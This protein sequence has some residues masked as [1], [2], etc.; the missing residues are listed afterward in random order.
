MVKDA[1]LKFALSCLSLKLLA[2]R[3]I[4]VRHRDALR[5]IRK[6][7]SGWLSRTA[8]MDPVSVANSI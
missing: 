8:F 1:G 4:G 6:L 5:I 2:T 3:V 7:I